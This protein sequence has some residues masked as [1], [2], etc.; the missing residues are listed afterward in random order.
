M[1]LDEHRIDFLERRVIGLTAAMRYEKL[2]MFVR[3]AA[4]FEIAAKRHEIWLLNNPRRASFQDEK[5]VPL[6]TLN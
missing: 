2:P 3:V 6:S 4:A 1:H 5:I